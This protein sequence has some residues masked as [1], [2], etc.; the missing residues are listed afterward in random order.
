MVYQTYF[1]F[2][3]KTTNFHLQAFVFFS[4]ICSYNFHWL[5]AR[6]H[7]NDDMHPGIY[8]HKKFNLIVYILSL[9]PVGWYI[10]YFSGHLHWLLI[11]AVLTFLYTAPKIPL[12]PFARLKKIAFGKTLFLSFVWTYVT[13]VLPFA[14]EG[15]P[16][17]PEIF[18]YITCQFFFIFSICI[19]FDYRDKKDDVKEGIRSLVIYLNEKGIDILF[20]ISV[21]LAVACFIF[22]AYMEQHKWQIYI[23]LL[24]QIIVAWLYKYAKKNFSEYLYYFILDG[25]MMFSGILIWIVNQF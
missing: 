12:H 22:L 25:M 4:T 13:S 14:V 5:I 3:P 15:L 20:I 24:P 8:R 19:L 18:I 9:F 21:L 6:E 1:L 17:T 10:F 11:A 2:I 23:L 16:I 7:I